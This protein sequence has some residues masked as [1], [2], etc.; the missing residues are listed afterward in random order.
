[1]SEII[2]LGCLCSCASSVAAG[3]ATAYGLVP[4]T[5]PYYVKKYKLEELEEQ[6]KSVNTETNAEQ[7]EKTCRDVRNKVQSMLNDEEKTGMILGYSGFSSNYEEFLEKYYDET[8]SKNAFQKC[9]DI[10]K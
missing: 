2:L 5:Q 9:D 4:N 1:M 6:F 7:K 3:F 10:L 8:E